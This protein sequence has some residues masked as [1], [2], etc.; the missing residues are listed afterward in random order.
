MS[1]N[2]KSHKVLSGSVGLVALAAAVISPPVRANDAVDACTLLTESQ[3]SAALG[4]PVDA[5]VRPNSNEPRMCNWRESHKPTGPGRNVLLTMI[6]ANEFDDLKKQPMSAPT[7][8]V[9]DEAVTSH[10]MHVPPLLTVKA[11]T[12]Y[13]Q[14]LVRSDLVSSEEVDARDQAV[15]K[16]LAAKIIKKLGKAQS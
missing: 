6:S 14:I 5:G 7:S 12:H 8:G 4:I 2:L 15:E 3:V 16:T 11:G 1:G 13:F 9:G 10:P